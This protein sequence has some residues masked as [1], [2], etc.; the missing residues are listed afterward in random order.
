MA[1]SFQHSN[2]QKEGDT[3]VPGSER[4]NCLY[5]SINPGYMHVPSPTPK[6]RETQK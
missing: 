1:G 5:P 6:A 3:C 2:R 4:E